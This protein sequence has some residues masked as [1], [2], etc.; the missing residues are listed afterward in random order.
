MFLILY[1]LCYPTI[2]PKGKR[3][4]AAEPKNNEQNTEGTSSNNTNNNR[5]RKEKVAEVVEDSSHSAS[6]N[7]QAYRPPA[8][9]LECPSLTPERSSHEEVENVGNSVSV[10]RFTVD[11][12]DA[13]EAHVVGHSSTSSSLNPTQVINLQKGNEVNSDVQGL[14]QDMVDKYQVKLVF[15]P[16]VKK[17]ICKH[18]D[19][20]KN[21]TV[22]TT[23]Y[24]SKLLEMICNI[25]IDLQEKK[26]SETNEDHLQDIV[27]LL[28][29]MKN[30]NVDV[31]WLHQRLVEILQ[32][33]E[34]LKQTSMLKE[35]REFSRQKVENTEKELKEK[36]IDKDRLA[37]LLKAACAEVADCKEKLAAARDESARIDE[38]IAD[39]ESKAGRFLN[40]SLVDDLL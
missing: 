12:P 16:I 19:I 37:I 28:D 13:G 6:L 4:K 40:C 35:K 18:G 21:C 23:K 20:F 26:F 8:G 29:D 30:K 34:V 15:M 39:S 10:A 1:C 22:V 24:R 2:Q 38:T 33:R 27:L 36:E 9:Y 14:A 7:E 3:G 17:L 5:E 32:A 11:K 31:E 25:I